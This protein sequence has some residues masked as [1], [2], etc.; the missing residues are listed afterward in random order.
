[1]AMAPLRYASLALTAT[2]LSI[3]RL[4]P[5]GPRPLKTSDFD[6]DAYKENPSGGQGDDELP[7]AL[8]MR[9]GGGI[10][11]LG[12]VDM[13]MGEMDIQQLM[14]QLGSP[15][16]GG[17]AATGSPF[18]AYGG[19]ETKNQPLEGGG[20]TY[21]WQQ[22]TETLTVAAP[23]PDGTRAKDVIV[24]YPTRRSVKAALKGGAGENVL[25]EGEL[26][27]AVIVDDSFWSLDE[28]DETL[29]LVLDVQKLSGSRELWPGFLTREGD[30]DYATITDTVF[31]DVALDGGDPQRVEIGLFGDDAPKTA[32]NFKGL[33]EGFDDEDGEFRSYAGS[34]FH[35]VIPGFMCQGG[36]VTNGDGTGGASIYGGTF[37]DEA[38][39]FAHAYSG[40]VA[41][42][43][44][45][46]N[47]N[48]SQFY[49]TLADCTWLDGKHVVFGRVTKGMTETVRSIEKLGS[50]SGD[51]S[52]ECTI[53]RCGVVGA[54]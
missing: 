32:A 16:G 22:T 45:G 46:P 7:G 39:P 30:S 52:G 9:G 8:D 12:D 33:C 42:A 48:K 51:L 17:D 43:N 37:D 44:S 4:A 31:F 38:F 40:L 5:R 2:A 1:M 29:C 13:G 19:G 25:F 14:A 15:G 50:N 49:V 23:V 11:D 47:T 21:V 36:D 27:G 26:R 53:V 35:R 6:F 54:E 41:M 28:Q 3:A 24:E 18:D 10:A 20:D 34:P